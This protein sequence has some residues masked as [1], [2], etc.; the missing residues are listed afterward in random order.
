[1][2]RCYRIFRASRLAEESG[3]A[4]ILVL[5]FLLLG[6]LMLVPALD[7]VSTALKTGI[8]YEQKSDALYAADAGIEDGI[9]QIKYDGLQPKFGGDPA[10]NY[11]FTGNATYS[12]DNPVN[13]LTTNV[14][15]NN[16]WVPTNVTLGDLGLSATVAQSMLDSGK[17]VIS[18]TSGVV[19]GQPYHIMIQF[20]P[21]TGDN[22][23]IKSVGIWL[24]RAPAPSKPTPSP[25]IIRTR[26][27][28]FPTT[29][30]RPSS[31]TTTMIPSIPFSPRSPTSFPRTG[32]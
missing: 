6:S 9:W 3:Q 4:L 27:R 17:L 24:P 20:V 1:M 2:K 26:S 28:P 25:I 15:I 16:I 23:T 22:L 19:P 12:L 32:P 31:G 7:H 21:D 13:G 10:F 18:G 14:T 8:R 30:G 29:A 11:N 5:L